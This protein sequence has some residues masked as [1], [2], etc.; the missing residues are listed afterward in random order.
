MTKADLVALV[1][2]E[3]GISKKAAGI[4]VD[5][6]VAAIQDALRGG[7]KIRVT[8][9]GSF[10]V[11]QRKARKGVNPRTGKPIDIPASRAPK[12]SAAKALRDAVKK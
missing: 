3:A 9:L 2:E 6:L 8:D 10:G 4:A 11:V 1:S 12:F 5:S 7:E